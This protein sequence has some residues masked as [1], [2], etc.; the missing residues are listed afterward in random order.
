ML[1]MR[2]GMPM[3]ASDWHGW[4]ALHLAIMSNQTE[5][6]KSLLRK[7]ADV[8]REAQCGSTPLHIAAGYNYTKVARLLLG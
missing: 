2:D 3:S 8:N 4:T 6:V 5:V 7:G 1:L